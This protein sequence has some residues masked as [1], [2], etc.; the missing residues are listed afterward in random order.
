MDWAAPLLYLVPI[1]LVGGIRWF[2]KDVITEGDIINLS[3]KGKIDKCNENLK[4]LINKAIDNYDIS[5]PRKAHD[6][7]LFSRFT[8]DNYEL[9]KEVC[10]NED[11]R[12]QI[13]T[14]NVILYFSFFMAMILGIISL[15][16]WSLKNNL[17]CFGLF[18]A[19]L[20][21]IILQ[22]FIGY[23]YNSIKNNLH[24]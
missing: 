22:F 14:L 5:S 17:L 4:L 12:S 18:C 6:V 10:K 24:K 15:I 2:Y 20:V 9:V 21:L 3:C 11:Y 7:D 16:A 8:K 1:L 13:R 23:S 19:A